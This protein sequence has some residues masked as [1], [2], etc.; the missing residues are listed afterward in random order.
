M[1]GSRELSRRLGSV[2]IFTSHAGGA[3][4]GF[5]TEEVQ[6]GQVFE[7]GDLVLTARHT[8]GHTPEHVSFL[9]AEAARK[10]PFGIFS[11]DTVFVDSVGRPDLLGEDETQSLAGQLF[12]SVREF[13]LKLDDGVILYP[14]HGA[15]S[16]CGP[17][18]GDRKGSTMGYERKF[19]PYLGISER[20]NSPER[21]SRPRR[22]S[23]GI[24]GR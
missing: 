10:E 3:E 16:A 6:D 24:T 19:N 20:R 9:V 1:S 8:P 11:G 5:E 22:R 15:G 12:Q 7:F 21:C 23:Q 2:P 18:I 14:G 4:Y 13:Y 17:D